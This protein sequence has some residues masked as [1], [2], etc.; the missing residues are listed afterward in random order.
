M[1]SKTLDT[2]IDTR[3]EIVCFVEVRNGN[4]NGDPDMGN[5]PRTDAAT[6]HGYMTDVSIKRVIRDYVADARG[7]EHGNRIFI[8]DGAVLERSQQE[9]FEATGHT[10]STAEVADTGDATKTKG[11]RA[12]KG[13]KRAKGEPEADVRRWLCQN[14]FDIRT[15]GAVLAGKNFAAGQINGPIQVSI[16]RSVD[17]ITYDEVAITRCAVSSEKDEAKERTIGRKHV[18]PYALY[19]IE[20]RASP[21]RAMGPKGSGFSYGDMALVEQA[22]LDGFEHRMTASKGSMATRAMFVFEHE[23]ALGDAPAFELMERISAVR[24]ADIPRRF[25]DYAVTADMDNLPSGV[26]LRQVR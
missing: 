14:F 10:S 7:G 12:T 22:L 4:P 25:A 21:F 8:A 15:F 19:R 16:S 23:S 24:V 1:D 17:P 9:A 2:P 18:V 6:G 20:V 26:T 3:R 5:A 13:A 11:G